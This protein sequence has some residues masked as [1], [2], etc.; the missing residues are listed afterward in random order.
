MG[1]TTLWI[2]GYRSPNDKGLT[3]VRRAESSKEMERGK[4]E[5]NL[6]E[7]MPANLLWKWHRG[8]RVCG[9]GSKWA[10]LVSITSFD[11][12]EVLS[13][14]TVR[15]EPSANSEKRPH[16]NPN[17]R[18]S[19][20]AFCLRIWEINVCCLK[21]PVCGFCHDCSGWA[22]HPP[23]ALLH[24]QPPYLKLRNDLCFYTFAKWILWRKKNHC[25][26]K[27]RHCW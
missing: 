8:S 19:H 12:S 7:T 5:E 21:S 10:A 13:S 9:G 20:L 1:R 11:Q 18:H 2:A 6:S 14:P 4:K 15:R 23:F 27:C 22:R 17:C 16:Q 3:E 26:Q 24:M 25:S